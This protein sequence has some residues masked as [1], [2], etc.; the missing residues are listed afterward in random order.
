M[1]FPKVAHLEHPEQPLA[2][3]KVISFAHLTRSLP[4]SLI[5]KLRWSPQSRNDKVTFVT[6]TESNQASY[7]AILH[8]AIRT[9][10]SDLLVAF[11]SSSH[12]V[13]GFIICHKL[14]CT[15]T[16]PFRL[17]EFVVPLTWTGCPNIIRV[18]H[19]ERFD[20]ESHTGASLITKV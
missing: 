14:G 3:E 15:R 5:K 2:R 8:W 4:F 19:Y 6:Q 13:S 7:W 1:W 16:L 20:I 17:C 12:H 9:Y 10:L 18:L 11:Y